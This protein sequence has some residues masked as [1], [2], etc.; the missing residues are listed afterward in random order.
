MCKACGNCS[1]QHPKTI[2]DSIDETIESIF[3][4]SGVTKN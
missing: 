3:T 4:K 2:D 1:K